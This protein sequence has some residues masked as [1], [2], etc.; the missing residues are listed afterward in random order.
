VLKLIRILLAPSTIIYGTVIKIR[1]R[2]FDKNIFQEEKVDSKVISVG[3][4]TVGGSGKTPLVINIAKYLKRHSV[5]VSVLSRGYG[6][7]TK[8][9][10]LVSDHERILMNVND[11]GDEIYLVAEECQIPTAVSEKRVAGAKKLLNQVDSDIIVLDDAFQHRWIARDFN[12][13]IIDQRF[14]SNVNSIDQRLLPLGSMREPFESIGRADAVVINRKF[15]TKI[16]VP[17]KIKKYLID[18]SIFYC[19]YRVSGI[20]D[21]KTNKKYIIEEFE[22]EHSLVVCGIARPFSFLGTLRDNN[23]NIKNKIIFNDHKEYTDKEIEQI[24]KKFYSTNS[25]SV[26]TTQKDAVK[27]MEFKKELDDIDIFYLK[28]DLEFEDTESFYNLLKTKCKL[29]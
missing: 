12:V 10:K 3:N 11:A 23:I 4:L 25:Y 21:V 28:I 18:Q 13:L 26:L 16:T 27:L 15:S 2:L 1:N 7:K 8:G 9:F 29:N 24:R 22:G 5:N 20:Y 17:S 6:R 14:L 19:Y